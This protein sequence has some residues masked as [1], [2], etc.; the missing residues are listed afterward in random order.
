MAI[1]AVVAVLVVLLVALVGATLLA[2]PVADHAADAAAIAV[3]G[4]SALAGGT[5]EPD[6]DAGQRVARANGAVLET[7]DL[8][9]WPRSVIV[10]VRLPL[11]LPWAEAHLTARAAATLHPP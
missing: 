9:G 2:R 7:L 8:A 5:G 4:G 6:V 11:H 1:T 3:L 10:T